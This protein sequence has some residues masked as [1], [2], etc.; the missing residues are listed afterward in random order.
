MAF[1]D[2]DP[3]SKF[4]PDD[5]DLLK[6][7]SILQRAIVI[8]AGVI[9][10]IVFAY[11]LLFTQARSHRRINCTSHFACVCT[12]ISAPS[13]VIRPLGC[14]QLSVPSK[15]ETL[16]SNLHSLNI[17][18]EAQKLLHIVLLLAASPYCIWGAC[19]EM[20]P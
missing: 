17:P 8:S 15:P 4:P 16:T 2:E 1:P 20:L 6:N 10:N 12:L 3:E 19:V 11:S 9:A 5:P 18:Q 7:R 13:F 14:C